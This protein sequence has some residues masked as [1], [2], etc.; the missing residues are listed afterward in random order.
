MQALRILGEAKKKSRCGSD[1]VRSTGEASGT[2]Y[3][4]LHRLTA[5]KLLTAKR[6]RGDPAKLG[7]PLRTYYSITAAGLKFLK[8]G[9]AKLA[10]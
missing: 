4:I 1:I 2:V 6:E 7:R 5:H 9:K 8:A 3:P 10:G